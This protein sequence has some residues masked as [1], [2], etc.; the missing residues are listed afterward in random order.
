MSIQRELESALDSGSSYEAL[1]LLKSLLFRSSGP[2]EDACKLFERGIRQFVA[3]GNSGCAIDLCKAFVE[4]LSRRRDPKHIGSCTV[5]A[6]NSSIDHMKS[7]PTDRSEYLKMLLKWAADNKPLIRR[8]D[9]AEEPLDL[10]QMLGKQFLCEGDASQAFYHFVRSSD[11][12]GCASCVLKL[13]NTLGYPSEFDLFAAQVILQLLVLK[14]VEMAQNVYEIIVSSDEA[15][16]LKN[17]RSAVMFNFLDLLIKTCKK[18]PRNTKNFELLVKGYSRVYDWDP[19]LEDYVKL[20]GQHLF[21]IPNRESGSTGF[22]AEAMRNLLSS[23][24]PAQPD[25][26]GEDCNPPADC[27]DLT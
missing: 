9:G 8:P 13:Q 20:I 15:N 17:S 6:I 19:V 23:S 4:S 16:K 21:A 24:P 3:C 1:Q 27:R 14:H 10:H 12:E 26:N 5:E 25:Q 7:F 2:E 11:A 18:Q 22:L